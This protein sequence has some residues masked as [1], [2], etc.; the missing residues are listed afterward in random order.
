MKTLLLTEGEVKRLLSMDE[1][2]KV[3]ESAFREKGLGRV[4]MPAKIYLFYKKYNGD[5]RAMPSYLE[6]LDISAVKIVNVHPDNRV[7]YGL[8]TVM[9]TIVLIDP[10]NGAPISIMGGTTITAM[11][12]GAAGIAFV[13]YIAATFVDISLTIRAKSFPFSFIP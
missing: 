6:N 3:V 5:L 1:V 9:A 7:K 10:K 12:T 4:Q 8:P 11:R 2:I 13:V